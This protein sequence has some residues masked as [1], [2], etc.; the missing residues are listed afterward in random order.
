ML[1]PE[2]ISKS[3]SDSQQ[4]RELDGDPLNPTQDIVWM[5]DKLSVKR[6]MHFVLHPQP[7]RP[8]LG[9]LFPS[10]WVLSVCALWQFL[11][12]SAIPGQETQQDSDQ[13]V[14]STIFRDS[15]QNSVAPDQGLYLSWQE[16]S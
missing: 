6:E 9:W 5:W 1:T 7:T 11:P 15:F 8:L 3:A 10:F 13:V 2:D 16:Q 4:L 12:A 14:C